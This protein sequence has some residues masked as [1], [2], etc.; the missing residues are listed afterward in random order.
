MITAEALTKRMVALRFPYKG[1]TKRTCIKMERI[2]WDVLDRQA[3]A[4]RITREALIGELVAS[5][6]A[7]PGLNG[8]LNLTSA[9]RVWALKA[10]RPMTNQL[11]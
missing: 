7:M 2:F 4:R 1:S 9:I 5:F 6:E 8:R 11:D 10:S 3:E